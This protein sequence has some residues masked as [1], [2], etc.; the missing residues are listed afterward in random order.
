MTEYAQLGVFHLFFFLQTEQFPKQCFDDSKLSLHIVQWYFATLI[1]LSNV[2]GNYHIKSLSYVKWKHH[3]LKCLKTNK[4]NPQK[5]KGNVT[6]DLCL[7]KY[8]LDVCVR[9]DRRQPLFWAGDQV[10]LDSARG[11]IDPFSP[12]LSVFCVF[13]SDS[14]RRMRKGGKWRFGGF[15]L[16]FLVCW[17]PLKHSRMLCVITDCV[18]QCSGIISYFILCGDLCLA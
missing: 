9:E 17:C 10:P 5:T 14:A 12:S 2:I 18:D 1:T 6:T 3:F 7:L 11:G 15:C 8:T 4:Q 16:C 13:L